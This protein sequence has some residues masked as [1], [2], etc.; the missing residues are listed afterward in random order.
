L[1]L[2]LAAEARAKGNAAANLNAVIA[3]GHSAGGSRLLGGPIIEAGNYNLHAGE[4]VTNPATTAALES[5]IGGRL[6][7]K[8]LL[9]MASG[10]GV[11]WNDYRHF[12]ADVS[13]ATRNEIRR[14]TLEIIESVVRK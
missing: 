4:F 11:V 3:T 7:Q 13:V 9:A 2:Q 5:M 12:E 14:D 6:T 8:N 10:S 1:N